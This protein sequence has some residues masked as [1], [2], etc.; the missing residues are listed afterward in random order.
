MTASDV[1]YIGL[2]ITHY[3]AESSATYLRRPVVLL[4]DLNEVGDR[5][6]SYTAQSTHSILLMDEKNANT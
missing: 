3:I 4:Q 2:D 5:Q 6:H 1:N